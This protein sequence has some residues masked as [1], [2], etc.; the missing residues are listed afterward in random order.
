MATIRDFLVKQKVGDCEDYVTIPSGRDVL[1]QSNKT[2]IGEASDCAILNGAKAISTFKDKK[3]I[4]MYYILNDEDEAGSRE[5]SQCVDSL[6]RIE[7]VQDSTQAGYKVKIV[8]DLKK[9]YQFYEGD[10]TNLIAKDAENADGTD[11]IKIRLGTYPSSV[12]SSKLGSELD[13]I[14]E[15]KSSSQNYFMCF[16]GSAPIYAPSVTYKGERYVKVKSFANN[17]VILSDKNTVSK[18]RNE[19]WLK[20]SPIVWTVKNYDEV[21]DVINGTREPE[22]QNLTLISDQVVLAGTPLTKEWDSSV[23][24]DYLNGISQ[25]FST[26]FLQS[27]D[28][29]TEIKNKK[30]ERKENPYV[31]TFQDL[32]ND[33]LLKSCVEA[34]VPVFL[35]GVS[36]IGKS[37]R[38]LELDPDAVFISLTNGMDPIEVKGGY[39]KITRQQ[40]P[41]IWYK[42]IK[43]IC[44]ADPKRNHILFIDELVN[45]RPSVQSLVYSIVNERKTSDG[46]WV[47]P[48]NCSIVA[49]GNEQLD[50]SAA[51]PLTGPLFRRFC[52]VYY[53][54]N[55][56]DF[57]SWAT[58]IDK[59]GQQRLHP[60][61]IAYIM[62]RE[63]EIGRNIKNNKDSI[64][65][66]EFDED[67][68]H[69]VTDPRKWAIASKL[70][71][72]TK[73]PFSLRSAVGD[74]ITADFVEF[75]KSIQLTV[76]DI[77]DGRYNEREF[78]EKNLSEK[79]AIISGLT[80][81]SEEQLPYVRDFISKMFG[82]E[83]LKKYDLMWIRNDPDRALYIQ[84]LDQEIENS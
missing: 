75:C 33:E 67:A 70:L 25:K 74:A 55:T 54:I 42:N 11:K 84:D 15:E 58:K 77:V 10:L 19:Y 13:K 73:N 61:I 37:T 59:N 60:A 40:D 36:G 18:I 64:L 21:A 79:L 69:I 24:R 46:L 2:R 26:S 7:D 53:K 57:L 51:F 41:P 71:F 49:A 23:I 44:E 34:K 5:I 6:G 45:V 81:A 48:E 27:A 56:E 32:T 65:Y 80:Y 9:L 68:P 47:L 4:A 3:N 66:Q 1:K 50:A 30:I 22:D 72:A 28:F 43:E 29:E 82:D 17:G 35:H 52:H 14:Y 83:L 62:A 78:V 76:E 38:V 20:V 63:S 12:C 16:E 31:F 39:N 8:L